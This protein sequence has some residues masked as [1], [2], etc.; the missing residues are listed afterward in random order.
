MRLRFYTRLIQTALLSSSLLTAASAAAEESIS[1]EPSDGWQFKA[2][3]YGWLPT[4]EGTLP[5]GDDMELEIDD[6]LDNLDFTFM[7]V[8]EAQKGKWSIVPD[9]VYL[10]LS[11]DEGGNTTVDPMP[12]NN[13][14]IPT[15]VD[16]GVEMEAWIVNLAGGYSVY[17]SNTHDFQVLAGVRYLSLEVTAELDASIIPGETV[18]DGRDETWD[19]IV[20]VRGVKKLSDKW[21]FNYRFDVGAGDSDQTWNAVAQLGRQYDW[22]SAVLGYRYLHYDFDSNFKLQEDLDVYG[23]LIGVA[24]EF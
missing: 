8:L 13:F 24:W 12:G 6:I 4:I 5:N 22:G 20:G 19:G 11:A 1:I 15:R 9:I 21:W 10:K 23:P 14:V 18:V 17:Q 7:G 2:Q 3:A 16:F